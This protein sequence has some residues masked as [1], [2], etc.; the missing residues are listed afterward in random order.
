MQIGPVACS[1]LCPWEQEVSQR[2]PLAEGGGVNPRILLDFPT[3]SQAPGLVELLLKGPV[4]LAAKEAS[5]LKY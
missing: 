4:S 5:L 1:R 3:V 2:R